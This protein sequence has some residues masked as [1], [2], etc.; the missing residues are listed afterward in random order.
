LRK[1][2]PIKGKGKGK[3]IP[4]HARQALKLP[5]V[6]GSQISRQP[7]H[8]D[9]KVVNHTHWPPLLPRKYSWYSFL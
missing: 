3:A 5:R 8:E 4:L 2:K 9:G 6:I 7:A 1:E